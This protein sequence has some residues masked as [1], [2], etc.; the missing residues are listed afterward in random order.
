M[1]LLASSVASWSLYLG[2]F[3]L[4]KQLGL[5]ASRNQVSWFWVDFAKASHQTFLSL[6]SYCYLDHISS[7]D[8]GFFW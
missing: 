8:L 5:S 7:T 6:F 3:D 2:D 1:K 4:W